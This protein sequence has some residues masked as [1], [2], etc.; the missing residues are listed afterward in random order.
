MQRAA[1]LVA[2]SDLHANPQ[3]ALLTLG[4]APAELRASPGVKVR[5][6]VRPQPEDAGER[7]GMR[8]EAAAP[9]ELRQG[10]VVSILRG[11]LQWSEKPRDAFDV[12]SVM[13]VGRLAFTAAHGKWAESIRS[14]RH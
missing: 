14:M 6:D 8:P 13:S 3:A 1:A 5:S 11:I 2:T 12:V 10:I 7:L 9:L 4:L